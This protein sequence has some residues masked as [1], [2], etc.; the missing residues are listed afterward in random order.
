M[1]VTDCAIAG[2][3]VATIPYNIIMQ[4][5]KHPLTESGIERFKNDYIKVFGE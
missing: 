3:D 2:A 5:A 4:M 1:H